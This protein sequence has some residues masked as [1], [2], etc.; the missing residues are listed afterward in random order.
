MKKIIASDLEFDN[1][2]AELTTGRDPN[3]VNLSIEQVVDYIES[4]YLT[5]DDENSAD[6]LKALIRNTLKD[7]VTLQRIYNNTL[8]PTFNAIVAL[9]TATEAELASVKKHLDFAINYTLQLSED[10]TKKLNLN[11][12]DVAQL[13]NNLGNDTTTLN[14]KL[15]VVLDQVL[16]ELSNL[17]SVV[18]DTNAKNNFLFTH[19]QLFLYEANIQRQAP[20]LAPELLNVLKALEKISSAQAGSTVTVDSVEEAREMA[21]QGGLADVAKRVSRNDGA[22]VD[23]IARV[24]PETFRSE[25]F[26]RSKFR[27]K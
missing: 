18:K 1:I 5:L 13:R 16:Q 20:T 12:P 25:I 24:S 22:S 3:G 8:K 9:P 11:D 15:R 14:G 10:I 2:T 6:P 7:T 21:D 17:H 19:K 4:I 23:H 27:N 26:S